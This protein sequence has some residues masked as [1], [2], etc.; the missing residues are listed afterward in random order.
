ML[1]G[2]KDIVSANVYALSN[3]QNNPLKLGQAFCF[4]PLPL[5]TGLTVQVNGYFEVSSNRR[6]IWYG[7]DMDRSGRIR[8]MWN[9]LLLEDIV[10]PAFARL[11]LGVQ[12]LLGPTDAYYSLWPS[13][14]FEKPWDILVEHIYKNI[15]HSHVLYSNIGGG[16]WISP[17]EAFHHDEG[18]AKSKELS[19]ALLQIG[20][21]IVS[22]P[23]YLFDMFL[24]CATS[25]QLKVMTPA[26]VR[27]FL[28]EMSLVNLSKPCK[29]VLFEYCLDDL[30]DADVGV[31]T[32]NL[33]LLP[34]ANGDFGLLSEAGKGMSYFICNDLEYMLLEQISERVVD[35]NIPDN[36]FYRLSSVALLS[37]ANLVV[38][39]VHHLP[40]FF[41]RFMPADWKYKI[42]V[43]WKPESC[44]AHPSKSW[45]SLFWRYL[46]YQRENVS[47]FYDW[48]ILPSTSGH[49]YRPLQ[50]KLINIAELSDMLQFILVKIGCKVLDI[51][52]G[53]ECCNLSILVYEPNIAGV[54]QAI[55]D[56]ASSNEAITQTLDTLSDEETD[57]LR[58]FLLDPKW[59]MG[60]FF[61]SSNVKS[62]M[63][64]P[65]YKVYGG[66]STKEFFS[67]LVNPKKYLPPFDVPKYLLGFEFIANLSDSEEEILLK[68]YDIE[69]MGKAQFYR[70]HVLDEINKFH[71]DVRDRVMLSILQNL[72]QLSIEDSS[73]K[74]YLRNLEFVSTSSGALKCPIVLY[75]PRIQELLDLLEDSDS[76]PCGPFQE[77]G[78]LDMLQ[79]LGLR[80][81][82]TRETIIE[83]ARQVERLM[84]DD[85]AKAN[86]KGKVLL[87]YLEV[88]AMK[89]LPNQLNVD[90]GD[91]VISRAASK[92]KPH[93]LRYDLEKFWSDLR[94][95][96]WCPVLDTTPFQAL[97]WPI[98]SSKVAPP[99]LVRLKADLW[100][101]SASMRILDGECSSTT[102]SYNLGWLSPPGGSAIAA[103]LL[104]LGKNNELVTDQV[105]R[106]ELALSM[107]KIYSILTHMI[108]SDEMEIVKA[109]LEGC[110]WI[111]V[112]DG[113]AMVDEV[114]LDGPL[115]LA[116]YLRV[117]PIDLAV[118]KDLFLELGIREALNPFDY[119]NILCRMA[120]RK[121]SSPLDALEIRA[122][123][124][125]AQHLSEVQCHK[126]VT[127]YLPD[128]SGRLY[129]ATDLVYNDAPWL[130]GFDEVDTLFGGSSTARLSAKWTSQKFIH[131]NI[132]NKVAEKIG[133]RSLRRILLAE[134][135]DSLNFSLAEACEAFGQHEALTTRL[136]H[137]LDMYA[138]GPGI[139]FEMV[140]N[141]EDAGAS[142]V[143]FLLDKTQYGTSSIL[144]PQM[145]KWQGPA[146]YCFNDSVFS[147]Q[148]LYAISCIGQES[149]VEKP[150]AVGRFG[151]G[152]NCVYH[153][154][155]VPAF[156]SG[157][158][159]VIFDPHA[160]N[161]PGISPSD[162]G[163]RI[164]FIGRKIL[165]QFPDQFTPFLQFGC[166]LC[167][168]FSGT[169]FRFPLRTASL[170]SQSQIK[171]EVYA[172][173]DVMSLFS[174][175]FASVS[176]ALLFL[177][178]VKSISV[179]VKE[180]IGQEMKALHRVE[181]DSVSEPTSN[182][183][184][185]IFGVMDVNEHTTIS[186]DQL[187]NKL[188]NIT[189]K[190]LPYRCQR[191]MVKEENMS[192]VVSHTWLT[193]ECLSNGRSRV[194]SSFSSN[195][196][197]RSVP[198][199]CVAAH[200]TS[201]E[202]TEDVSDVLN[203]TSS[204]SS[205]TS[206]ISVAS[207]ED[208]KTF[209]GRAFC[210]LPLPINTGLPVHVNAYFELSSNRRDIWFGSD[211]VGGGKERSDWN[212][213]LIENVVAP[214]YGRLLE[215]IAMEIGPCDQFFSFW[216]TLETLEP[217][218]SLIRKLYSFV[219]D[220]DLRVLYTKARGG[221]WVSPKQAILPDF[222]FGKAQDMCEALS[223]AGLPFVN[224]PK[225]VVDCFIDVCPSLHFLTPRLLRSLLVR[226]KR[227]FK[228]QKAMILILEYCL[229]DLKMP[230]Q[231]D[232]LYGLPLLPLADGSFTTFEKNGYGERIFLARGDEYGLLKDLLPQQLVHNQLPETI[233]SKLCNLAQ[234]DQSNVSFL[235][236]HLLEK[237]LMILLPSEWLLAKEV[238]WYPGHL[239]QPTLEWVKL[240][241]SYLNSHCD[242]LSIF[243]KWP[244]LPVEDNSLLQLTKS[245]HVIKHEGWS[246]N[247][248]SLLLKVG[249]RFLTCNMLIEHPQLKQYVHSPTAVGILNAFLAVVG[250]KEN[251]EGLFSDASEEELHELRNFLLQSKWFLEDY[252]DDLHIE[253]IKFIPMFESYRSR[254]LVSLGKL[255]KWLK[256][257]GI[258]EELVT[259]SFIRVESER[260]RIIVR[261]Y[262]GIGEPSKLEFYKAHVLNHMADFLSE[263]GA[264]EAILDD[265]KRLSEEDVSIKSA[266]SSTPFVLAADG[267][268]QKSSRYVLEYWLLIYVRKVCSFAT[269]F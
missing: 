207:T 178:N 175:F 87:S 169:L 27:Q 259:D 114:V 69:R 173:E 235:Y 70:K 266:L 191:I 256:P 213:Y 100:L 68:Y 228:D 164:K 62:C 46:Q 176:D 194:N 18:F 118:F 3:E 192:G 102:L 105:V 78:I 29:L 2:Y 44:Y 4:L 142:E 254:K 45:L 193:S 55:F 7:A 109:I 117:I 163:L 82:T 188:S 172:P 14:S 58:R 236:C 36:V 107:P 51:N 85:Q 108:G 161:L 28:R 139:L 222:A 136:R 57:E 262:L 137:I 89:W 158:N 21:P 229:L 247:M 153:F 148:D 265:V 37:N 23:S 182:A 269:Y 80:T 95:I 234:N 215:K 116:P 20:I 128:T 166:D 72:P 92:F 131:G 17:S 6:G 241:W 5:R 53:V 50:S 242:D 196:F 160:C 216:P 233:I 206:E 226:R 91:R 88:N 258:R 31:Y 243:S 76:F 110:R 251:I 40:D 86:S 246:E 42:K 127:I 219:T 165:E 140:Q 227:Q 103:Q 249:C 39:N 79:S 214:A 253:I 149:K 9:K 22:L 211:M 217:W 202:I 138:D 81:S 231:Q 111:W 32:A 185:Q 8:S 130:L 96:C 135:A 56:V 10:A 61:D 245:S 224:I 34:L 71:P 167:D 101:V 113:F 104:E 124:L 200:L 66:E 168:Y 60:D 25:F 150:F 24:K 126:Q 90:E 159:I 180:G 141:A 221:K 77:S 48:P 63:R 203:N 189:D 267:S 157:E 186:R 145:A 179:F 195:K 73:I 65:I 84:H 156:V 123:I 151:L 237:L 106:Q 220:C 19:D 201:V 35:R 30:I 171:K 75:D 268:W 119:A 225:P 13:G 152:F 155:D 238:S 47:L 239:G 162:P 122:T 49:L 112:G 257:D 43:L 54:L 210:F 132:S 212:L 98:T 1:Q 263:Q 99:K 187:L 67:D 177:R 154:T 183:R 38:F 264:V 129:P 260:E 64:L 197:L 184:H 121:G 120:S 59:Y 198:W 255:T 125:I 170:A 232:N 250:G 205:N 41:P 115:H 16:K 134:S 15:F 199:A 97:P 218:S 52:Y 230:V 12:E 83:S 244:I 11:L 248:S 93:H 26:A 181:R 240:L 261:K 143:V 208:A 133:V 146:L 94:M 190:D 74:E 252:M 147:H 33:A 144:S 174:S 204:G 209:G 223:D